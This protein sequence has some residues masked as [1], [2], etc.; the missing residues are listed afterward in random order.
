MKINAVLVV[1]LTVLGPEGLGVPRARLRPASR[2]RGDRLHRQLDRRPARPR[3]APRRRRLD[4]QAVSSRGGHGTDRGRRAPPPA[5]PDR[6]PTRARSSSGAR[7]PRRSVP[8]VRQRAE[9]GLTR[10]EFELLQLLAEAQG[11]VIER[12]EIYQRVWGYAM[13]HG[14]RSVDVFVRK[15]RAQAREASPGWSTSTP[16]SASA[17]ASIPSRSR[18]ATTAERPVPVE[19][20]QELEDGLTTR[21]AAAAPRRGSKS[22]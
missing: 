17:T 9:R 19:A 4:L 18:P 8:G 3:A 20:E 15:L 11:P 5:Q 12:E 22:A 14:D 16:T 1:D 2:P 7:D 10:R 13:A 21:T 6:G